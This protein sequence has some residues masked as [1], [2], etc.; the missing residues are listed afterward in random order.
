MSLV[1][2]LNFAGNAKEAVEFYKDVFNTKDPEYM[3]YGEMPAS[4]DFLVTE[5][6]KNLV[7]HGAIT[8]KDNKVMF[9]DY[10]PNVEF[11]SGNNFSILVQSDNIDELEG[12]YKAM[13]IDGNVGMP[14]GKTFFSE[15]FGTVTDKFGIEWQFY[16]EK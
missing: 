5:E 16:Y 13:E 7:M 4:D 11:K 3:F 12:Y 8:I 2:Y 9:S 1:I 14:L 10:L 15:C 6:N